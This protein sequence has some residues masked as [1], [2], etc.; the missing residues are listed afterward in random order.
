MG[1]H[2]VHLVTV[3]VSLAIAA[4]LA[5]PA[6]PRD[7]AA[8]GSET[9]CTGG[10]AGIYPCLGV[11]L[12]AVMPNGSIGGGNGNDI[13]GWTDPVTGTEYAIMGRTSGTSFVDISD[14][15]SPVYLGDLP[16]HTVD[17][18]WR[19]IKVY[20]DHAFIVSE[21]SGHGMQVFDLTQLRTVTSPPVTFSETTHYS[22]ID[23]AHNVVINE[24]SGFAYVVG[25]N[26]CSGG[27]HFVD[28]STPAS[29]TAAGCFSGDG[30]THDAQC[31]LYNGPDTAHQGSEICFALN[32][33]TLTI[34][35]VTNKATPSQ[36]SRT[37]YAGR[38][39]ANQGWLTE[40]HT[41]FL[42]TD[43]LDELNNGHNTRTRIWNVQ[44]LDNPFVS[45]SFDGPTAAIDHNIYVRGRR[46]YLAAYRA[47][48]RILDLT[49]I[50]NGNLAE[51][52]FF[53]VYP[54]N[55]FSNFGG[56]WSVYPFFDSGVVIVSSIEDGLFI[57]D[58]FR[59]FEDDLESGDTS[60]WSSAVP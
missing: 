3:C 55:D 34:V 5:G 32:E 26:T 51:V 15:T 19:D 16:T 49:D 48:L 35:D 59:I 58:P 20:A 21:A 9:A 13:W 37:D 11:D 42:M 44:D 8:P 43:E 28:I 39:Y 54:A 29:P 10:F 23:S 2:R 40:D 52:G 45:G 36:L 18:S 4:G 17:S 27:L 57:L 46:A 38:G 22:Q 60:A 25:S 53:D 33:D 30:Y 56:A 6:R 14:P 41:Y 1:R 12:L 24:D 7:A 31:V 50:V 47:G